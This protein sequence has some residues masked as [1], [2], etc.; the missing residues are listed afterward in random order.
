VARGL[1]FKRHNRQLLAHN[2][3]NKRALAYRNSR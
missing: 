2:G 3:I 1:W